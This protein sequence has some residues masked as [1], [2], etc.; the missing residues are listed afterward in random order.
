[1]IRRALE[2]GGRRLVWREAGDGPPALLFHCSLAFSGAWAGVIAELSNDLRLIA[3]DLPGHGG[4]GHVAGADAQDEAV[5]DAVR[6]LEDTGPAHLVGHSFGGTVA[7][8]VAREAPDRVRAL[9][10]FEPVQ[11]T[12]LADFDPRAFARERADAAPAHAAAREGDWPA[13]AEAFL[14]RWGAPFRSLAPESSAAI[15]SALPVLFEDSL[16]VS[17]PD[18]ARLRLDQLGQ[19][20]CPVLAL[21][22]STSPAV[23][24]RILDAVAEGV[25]DVTR[26]CLAGVGHMGPITH[27][28]LVSA[29]IRDFL[30]AQDAEEVTHVPGGR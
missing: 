2:T 28:A 9:V 27:P 22:G 3:P 1:L 30:G 21:C 5:A 17:E 13:A 4:T 20:A 16:S 6:L 8:R 15:L 18:Q 7:L 26:R 24:H 23:T 12:L 14:G 11:F 19:I 25:P 29:A 10:L